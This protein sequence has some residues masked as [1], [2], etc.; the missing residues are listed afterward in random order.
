MAAKVSSARLSHLADYMRARVKQAESDVN[1]MPVA[2]SL[3]GGPAS[4]A[5]A[6]LVSSID[7]AINYT[8]RDAKAMPKRD[9][10]AYRRADDG[11][12]PRHDT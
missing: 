4:P 9:M 2:A 10:G 6:D 11:R 1:A 5:G 8:K 7:R 3:Q 12:R